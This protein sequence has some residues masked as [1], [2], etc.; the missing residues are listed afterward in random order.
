MLGIILGL[1]SRGPLRP[2]SSNN[3]S[4]ARPP[5]SDPIARGRPGE[6]RLEDPDLGTVPASKNST[7]RRRR[8]SDF[9]GD[10]WTAHRSER[11]WHEQRHGAHRQGLDERVVEDARLGRLDGRLVS[12]VPG[13]EADHPASRKG[14]SDEYRDRRCAPWTFQSGLANLPAERFVLKDLA[15]RTYY[16]CVRTM[17]DRRPLSL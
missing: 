14:E 5:V 13:V 3:T 17:D 6:E 2:L 16:F 11:G 4:V 10:G 7:Q 1:A 15:A 9:R 12:V 8:V